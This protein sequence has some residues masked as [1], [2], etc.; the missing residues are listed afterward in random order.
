ME[1]PGPVIAAAAEPLFLEDRPQL[2]VVATSQ[3]EPK[4]IVEPAALS[5]ARVTAELQLLLAARRAARISC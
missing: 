3:P 5:M 2:A 1:P 4:P